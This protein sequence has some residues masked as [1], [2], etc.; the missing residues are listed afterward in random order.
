MIRSRFSLGAMLVL[1][2]MALPAHA[3]KFVIEQSGMI[4][5]TQ[6][7]VIPMKITNAG[8]LTVELADLAWLSRLSNLSFSVAR[9]KTFRPDSQGSTQEVLGKDVL[10]ALYTFDLNGPGQYYAYVTGTAS[11]KYGLGLFSVKLSFN[12]TAATVPV[13]AA[14]LLL[15]S[16]LGGLA[17]WKRRVSRRIFRR[18]NIACVA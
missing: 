16:A 6:S 3:E 2:C 1:L 8:R 12:E 18:V 10:S 11:G 5:G 17:A 4:S 13:P 9:D 15:L 14:G 7:F